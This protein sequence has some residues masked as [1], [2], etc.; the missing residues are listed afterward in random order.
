MLGLSR[1]PTLAFPFNK[2][3]YS[4]SRLHPLI[5]VYSVALARQRKWCNVRRERKIRSR[6]IAGALI[7]CASARERCA[8]SIASYTFRRLA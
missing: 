6:A 4:F 8:R 5:T 2:V 1:E 7:D 3:L